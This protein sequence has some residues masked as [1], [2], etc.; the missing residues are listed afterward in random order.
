MLCKRH[1]KTKLLR[2]SN[3]REII[4]VLYSYQFVPLENIQ[5]P[6]ENL[7]VNYLNYKHWVNEATNH[8]LAKEVKLSSHKHVYVSY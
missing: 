1:S 8:A 5:I 2:I 6:I 7:G 4:P 3:Q